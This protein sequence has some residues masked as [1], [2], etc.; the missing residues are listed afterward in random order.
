MSSA[1]TPYGSSDFRASYTPQ[2]LDYLNLILKN[3]Q[4]QGLGI[5]NPFDPKKML[6]KAL[7]RLVVLNKSF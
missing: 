5:L 3:L 7:W 4:D 1:I 6:Q 2:E